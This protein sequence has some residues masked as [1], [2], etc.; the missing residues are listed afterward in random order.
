MMM[1]R[2]RRRRRRRRRGGGGGGEGSDVGLG[3]KE[4]QWKGHPLSA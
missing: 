4:E 2:R 1:M 3:K